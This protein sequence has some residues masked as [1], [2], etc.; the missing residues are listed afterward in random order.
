[1][2]QTACNEDHNHGDHGKTGNKGSQDG[3][4]KGHN[5]IID[6]KKLIKV[7]LPGREQKNHY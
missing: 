7:I 3:G 6:L 5:W 2:G 4:S 1:M